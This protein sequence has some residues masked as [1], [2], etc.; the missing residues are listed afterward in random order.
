ME[1]SELFGKVD[2]LSQEVV[3]N[4]GTSEEQKTNQDG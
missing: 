2:D 4:A 3:L 1:D